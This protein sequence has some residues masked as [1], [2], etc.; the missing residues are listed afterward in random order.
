MSRRPSSEPGLIIGVD[1]SQRHN[2]IAVLDLASGAITTDE[3]GFVE[4]IG[5]CALLNEA[6]RLAAQAGCHVFVLVECP[7]WSGRG[8]KEVRSAVLVWERAL[9]RLFPLR[10][11]R[12]VDPRRW[13]RQLLGAVKG[14]DS[15]ALSIRYASKGLNLAVESDHQADAACICEYARLLV[16]G[17]VRETK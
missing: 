6:A 8:T 16:L 11:V 3:F 17:R 7:T 13:Q 1:P 10:T 12:R 9:H 14:G 4:E 5:S 15:K 2:G